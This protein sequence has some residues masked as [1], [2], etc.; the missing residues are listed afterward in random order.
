MTTKTRQP[1]DRQEALYWAHARRLGTFTAYRLAGNSGINWKSAKIFCARWE[2]DGLIERIGVGLRR[3]IVFRVVEC[4][5]SS[6]RTARTAPEALWQ[7]VRF[8]GRFT[9]RELMI[10]AATETVP[11]SETAA[12]DFVRMLMDGDYLR[13]LRKASPGLHEAEYLLV[14]NSGPMAPQIRRVRCV[15]DPNVQAYAHVP[16]PRQ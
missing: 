1:R 8:M 15:W 2:A 3:R 4:D 11:V 7:T 10:N 6:P 9:T 5:P 16:E 12:R 13:V 14:K